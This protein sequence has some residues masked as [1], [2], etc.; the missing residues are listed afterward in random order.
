M[1]EATLSLPRLAAPDA[2]RVREAVACAHCGLPCLTTRVQKADKHFCCAGCQ[3]VY[4]ILTEN[5][6]GQFYQLS[7]NA[8]VTIQRTTRRDQFRY[9]DEPAVRER[10]VDFTDGQ[11]S[12]VTFSIPTIHCV[13]CVWLLENLFRLNP[14]IGAVS[15]NF[16]RREATIRF[17]SH[18]LALS[19][20]V[21]LLAS[22][23]YE[24]TLS[25]G[26]LEGKA[27][28]APGRKTL[29]LRLGLAGFAFGNIMLI[30]LCL[31]AGLDSRSVAKFGSLF[32][33]V[34]FALA[35]PVFVFSAGEFWRSAW[36]GFRQRV[37][38]IDQPIAVGIAAIFAWSTWEI[39]SGTG[40][41]Y[42][43][44]LCA[45]I[46]LLLIGR[47]FQQKT[48]DRLSFDRDFKSFF[49]LAVH[50]LRDGREE[51]I[52]L[53][54]LA[55]GDRLILRHGDLIPAD[56]RLCA[57]QALVDYSFVTGEANPVTPRAG[58][59]LYAGGQQ[60]AGA[61]EIETVKPVSQSYLTSLWSHAAFAKNRDRSLDNL[62]NRFS[63]RFVILVSLVAFGA[64]GV[65]WALGQPATALRAFTAV[66]I[67]A[68]PCALALTAP[69]ALGTAQRLLA[70]RRIFLKNTH[71]LETLAR[72]STVVFDKTGT[73]TERG[74]GTVTFVGDPLTPAEAAAV[75]ALVGQSAH[76][77][78]R[79]IA[80]QFSAPAER[81]AL[82]GF[83]EV[84]GKGLRATIASQEWRL[85]S[86]SWLAEI[87]VSLPDSPE[88][89]QV[90]LAVA[91]RLR[92]CFRLEN[93]LRPATGELLR[94]LANT[95]ELALLSGDT[96]RERERFRALFGPDAALHFNQ[97]PVNKLG[98]IESLQREGRT[99]MM[100]GDG[101]NDAGAL[102]QSD[103]GV[104]VVEN[105]GAFSPAS[106]V[107]LEAQ[108]VP[109][110]GRLLRFARGAV[111]IVWISIAISSAYNV[112]GLTIA[113]T[114]RLSP[115]VCAVL[116]PISSISVVG[117]AVGAA[118]WLAR[119]TQL[120]TLNPTPGGA[121][122]E[123]GSKIA[124]KN[125]TREVLA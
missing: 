37:L 55:V 106:D 116:M 7:D 66:L 38:T 70:R 65:W 115:L 30:S 87:G 117:F 120:S 36:L 91:G 105:V 41:G 122:E 79:R 9:L 1:A 67:V 56:A 84:A 24:P 44:S 52:P 76:P 68:C 74:Q 33:W 11:T 107:I 110:L 82:E 93:T 40:H 75:A 8:G 26:A 29:L 123:I 100:V 64:G 31:Y 47:W 78:S 81:P 71:V 25:F 118:H 42:F 125:G 13:A 77:L 61:I 63:K 92:G 101:L 114:G 95:H 22:L 73:L 88:P 49:P 50:R 57:G 58:E 27:L 16:P 20:L 2:T 18:R 72:I 99:V 6:L 51:A 12:R 90:W 60:M 48:Y 23:G 85:G 102:R 21:A 43:D 19:E 46:F 32:G 113:A 69:F 104:A 109:E 14:A 94:D 53:S 39:A 96:E 119:R 4:E 59:V 86:A 83:A 121:E 97:S 15:V 111:R 89:G 17:D 98:F 34:S 5:G 28:P 10:L 45:L 108:R 80:A 103:V 54:Q 3:T 62:L 124:I 112:V 35:L